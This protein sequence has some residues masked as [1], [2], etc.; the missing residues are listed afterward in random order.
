MPKTHRTTLAVGAGAARPADRRD[1]AVQH[2]LRAVPDGPAKRWL[3]R[4]L[5]HGDRAESP[6]GAAPVARHAGS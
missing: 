1:D 5:R 2:C 4:L 6:D 3:A